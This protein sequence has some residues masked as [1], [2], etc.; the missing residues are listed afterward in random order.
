MSDSIEEYFQ[1]TIEGTEL[2]EADLNGDGL[3]SR[4]SRAILDGLYRLDALPRED[5]FW[6]NTNNRATIHKLGEF[7]RLLLKQNPA[8]TRA[9]WTLI[10]LDLLHWSNIQIGLWK[11]L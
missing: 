7:C 8:N 1:S 11:R 6:Q 2:A 10:G 4:A 5:P 3:F 9:I